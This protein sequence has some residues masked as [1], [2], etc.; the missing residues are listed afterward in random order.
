MAAR[1]KHGLAA[2]A[3]HS[4]E[5]HHSKPAHTARYGSTVARVTRRVAR[6]GL[7]AATLA[8]ARRATR[9]AI[10]QAIVLV[11]VLM[12]RDLGDAAAVGQRVL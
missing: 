3:S 4:C 8:G 1:S 6:E 10:A 12:C 11:L 5:H 2:S 9:L 7:A